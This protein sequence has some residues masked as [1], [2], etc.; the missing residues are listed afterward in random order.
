MNDG[1]NFTVFGV[2][3]GVFLVITPVLRW[4]GYK[5]TRSNEKFLLGCNKTDPVIIAL[6]YGATF[7]LAS[8]VIGFDGQ[9]TVHEMSVMWLCLLNLFMD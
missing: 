2:M 6:S 3:T 8:V 7:L 5:K 1:V 4:Y 9:A